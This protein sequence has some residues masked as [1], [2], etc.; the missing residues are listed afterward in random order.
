MRGKTIRS[1]AVAALG[2]GGLAA[3]AGTAEAARANALAAPKI[4][5]VVRVPAESADPESDKKTAVA[6]CPAGK[7]VISG[8]GWVSAEQ[9]GDV[10]KLALIELRPFYSS[11]VGSSG[12][13]ASA[14]ET[15]VVPSAKWKV[16]AYA[17]CADISSLKGWDLRLDYTDTTDR[18][19]HSKEVGC[20]DPAKQRVVGTG[21]VAVTARGQED[22][23][24]LQIA[25]PSAN[26]DIARAQSQ[27]VDP[28]YTGLHRLDVYAI[29]VDKPQGYEVKVAPSPQKDSESIKVASANCSSGRRLLG[30]GGGISN[31]APPHIS[32]KRVIPSNPDEGYA[33]VIAGEHTPTN[34]NWDF[35]TA[36][37]ICA[38]K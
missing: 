36:Y 23:V 29:C 35:I 18:P 21:A 16:H 25:R 31:V 27:K 8:G 12:Y 19:K 4:T 13:H 28:A 34:A 11:Q 24:T 7:R 15:S 5:G 30:A 9:S 10:A 37:A 38:A 3:L 1:L 22:K 32:L 20:A 6:T 33:Q 14:V 17:V 2:L 26:G